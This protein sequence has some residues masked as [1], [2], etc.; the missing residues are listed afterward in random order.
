MR[1]PSGF[2]VLMAVSALSL[3]WGASAPLNFP[4]GGH[5]NYGNWSG[6]VRVSEA[7]WKPGDT[8]TVDLTLKVTATS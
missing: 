8:V 6:A 5:T 4:V 7:A 2:L 3:G 1:N